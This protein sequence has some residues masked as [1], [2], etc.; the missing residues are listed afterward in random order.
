MEGNSV[1]DRK[2]TTLEECRVLC[3]NNA[4]CNSIAFG[5]FGGH[6]HLKDKCITHFE[7]QKIKIGYRSNYKSC[8]GDLTYLCLFEL[9]Y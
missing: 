3:D 1:G 5:G 6:C 9:L 7:P 2:G 4:G 8:N